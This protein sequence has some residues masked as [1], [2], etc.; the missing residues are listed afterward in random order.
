MSMTDPVADYLTR[1]RN[2][3]SAKHAKVDIPF[4]RLKEE[5]TRLLLDYR[6][7]KS[8]IK[9]DDGKQGLIRIYLKYDENEKSVIS[10]LR[11]VSKPGLRQYV[12]A[13]EVPR[14]L[15]NLGIAVLS[16]SKGVVTD[17]EARQHNVGGEVLCYIW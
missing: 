12:K 1:I 6:Y 17:R 16:T 9:I 2:A 5:I 15:N 4:S 11:K 10:E 3:I 13:S 7:I 14:V 8:Y